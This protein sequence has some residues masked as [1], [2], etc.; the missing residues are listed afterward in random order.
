M[1]DYQSL[2]TIEYHYKQVDCCDPVVY[3]LI[4]TLWNVNKFCPLYI[5][6]SFSNSNLGL[7]KKKT[8]KKEL[9]LESQP[10]IDKVNEITKNL[11]T[12]V[13]TTFKNLEVWIQLFNYNTKKNEDQWEDLL[14]SS[15]KEW[16]LSD[17]FGEKFTG[18]CY[19]RKVV[20]FLHPSRYNKIEKNFRN[21]FKEQVESKSDYFCF[22]NKCWDEDSRDELKNCVVGSLSKQDSNTR[23]SKQN[24]KHKFDS[25]ALFWTKENIIFNED[26]KEEKV[27]QNEESEHDIELFKSELEYCIACTGWKELLTNCQNITILGDLWKFIQR[28]MENEMCIRKLNENIIDLSKLDL[29]MKKFGEY[30]KLTDNF[31]IVLQRYL[32]I[33]PAEL[34]AFYEFC[35]NLDHKYLSDME[36]KFEKEKNVLH[37]F[38]KEFQSMVDRVKSDLFHTMW[39]MQITNDLNPISTI[40]DLIGVFKLADLHWNTLISKIK[41]NTLQYAD[42]EIYSNIKW[43]PEMNILL[44]DS[45]LQ[46]QN[47]ST[48]FTK[49]Q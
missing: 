9:N 16:W 29:A 23:L 10:L 33:I 7:K 8:Q 28:T 46:V 20:W 17:S 19:H 27:P 21:V 42:L 12:K 26:E 49:H 25:D 5:S 39:K 2:S 30:K 40:V 1:L 11:L 36:T 38:S 24:K 44:S 3:R 22:D 6:I 32:L 4:D 18:E 34:I 13:T 35:R 41:D 37:N 47:G 14:T 15:L 43:E 31:M 45:K 48:T